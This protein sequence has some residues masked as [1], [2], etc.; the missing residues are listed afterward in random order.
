MGFTASQAIAVYRR[1]TIV[2][3]MQLLREEIASRESLD[4]IEGDAG[5]VRN[6]FEAR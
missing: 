1:Q 2:G 6:V 3:G 5:Q 4:A